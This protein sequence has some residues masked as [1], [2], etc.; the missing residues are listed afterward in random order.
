MVLFSETVYISSLGTNLLIFFIDRIF[1]FLN[2]AQDVRP[3]S[4]ET[5]GL[6]IQIKLHSF[7]IPLKFFFQS[8]LSNFLS[9]SFLKLS[10][11][12]PGLYLVFAK[13]FLQLLSLLS[14]FLFE[15]M[16]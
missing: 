3:L 6:L 14:G 13:F 15:V 5:L 2:F 4:L 8:E 9:S 12:F 10:F 16:F 7:K 1:K 11:K